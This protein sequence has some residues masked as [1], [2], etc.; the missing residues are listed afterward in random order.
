MLSHAT[1]W[2]LQFSEGYGA[3]IVLV[4]LLLLFL[5][6]LGNNQNAG[7][8]PPK[9]PETI[10]FLSNSFQLATNTAGFWARARK[11]MRS[12]NTEILRFRLGRRL[13]Y[14]VVGESKTNPLF[15]TNTGLTSH[16]FIV[17][18][19][20]ILFGPRKEDLMRFDADV[21]GRGKEPLPGTEHVHDR[22]WSGWHH[23]FSEHLVRTNATK[24]L[25]TWFF[26]G[27]MTRTTEMFPLDT[28][29]KLCV[30]SFLHRHLTEC[31]GRALMGDVLFDEYPQCMDLLADFDLAVMPIVFGAPR[32]LTPKPHRVREQWLDMHRSFMK[33]ALQGYNWAAINNNE[34]DPVL[35]A[36]L[37]RS[38]V[39][40][41]L[42]KGFSPDTV[43]G[44]WGQQ[45]SNQNSNSVPAAAWCV[46][47]ALTCPDPELLPNLRREARAAMITGSDG[48]PTLDLPK[49]LT[50]PWLQ[51][52][53]AETLRMRVIFSIVR[54][55]ERDANVDG[56]T[57]PKGA[58][59]Q[60]PIPLAHFNDKAWGIDGHPPDEFWPQRHLSGNTAETKEFSTAGRNGYWFPY[61]GGITMCPGRNFAKQQILATLS[62]FLTRFDIEVEGWIMADGSGKRSDREA[63]NGDGFAVV[64]PDRDLKLKVRRKW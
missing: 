61:G 24:D 46:M 12:L 52:V 2:L 38:L 18:F 56:F 8:V 62:L 49:L 15:R 20:N 22:I 60:A 57:V 23:I 64:R 33:R 27:F 53:Y 55:V 58:L 50:S 7:P 6:Q 35:G 17:H 59:I 28:P 51:S 34:W 21:T 44:M 4:V 47:S 36:P 14:L 13:V 39:R 10:P 26:D 37:T 5:R 29:T 25:A 54:D 42:D 63:R 40:W 1:R 30:W 11:A 43:A 9:L 31:A 19:A 45:M 48:K 32:W 3:G 16:Y 41:A